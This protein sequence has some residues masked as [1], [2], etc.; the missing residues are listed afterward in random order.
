VANSLTI[1]HISD[2][3]LCQ[4]WRPHALIPRVHRPAQRVVTALEDLVRSE[5][6]NADSPVA[7]LSG[8]LSLLGDRAQGKHSTYV[9]GNHD[10]WAGSIR[11]TGVASPRTHRLVSAAYWPREKPPVI[12]L[13]GF[14]VRFYLLDTTPPGLARNFLALGKSS[15]TQLKRLRDG[16][17]WDRAE[18][19]KKGRACLAVVIM[20]HP[21]LVNFARAGII[22]KLLRRP[23]GTT[24][25]SM[26]PTEFDQLL[27]DDMRIGLVL[28]GH[29]HLWA[30]HVKGFKVPQAISASSTVSKPPGLWIHDLSVDSGGRLSINSRHVEY[31]NSTR[32]FSAVRPGPRFELVA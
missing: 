30:F 8:D 18:D 12:D 24:L 9:L 27:F 16:V 17:Q 1:I 13:D 23:P 15:S 14:R 20:H 19:R 11:I 31:E 21:M 29:T 22:D 3:H 6:S 7:V 28:T 5:I 32:A 25:R 10:F 26:K 4:R 2:I